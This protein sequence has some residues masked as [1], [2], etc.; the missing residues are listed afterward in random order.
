[1][2]DKGDFGS[3]RKKSSFLSFAFFSVELL[4]I[5]F[6][7]V[8][9][10]FFLLFIYSLYKLYPERY[11]LA[12]I[13]KSAYALK[14]YNVVIWFFSYILTLKVLSLSYSVDEEY[15]KY[16]P[17]LVAIPVS[18]CILYLFLMVATVITSTLGMIAIYVVNWLPKWMQEKYEQSTFIK[19]TNMLQSLMII[20]VIPFFLAALSAGY[21]AKIAIFLDASFI[22]DCG[23]KQGGVMYMRKNNDECYKF[24]LNRNI[25]SEPPSIVKSKK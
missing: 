12:K 24:N 17:A 4:L 21:V 25:F 7:H 15:L 10:A 16:S 3:K 8:F 22:S 13:T 14:F 6:E 2:Y 11:L 5:S 20:L 19:V 1:M 9:I 18:I 23:A